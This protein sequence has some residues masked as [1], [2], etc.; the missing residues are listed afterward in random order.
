MGINPHFTI[1]PEAAK[2]L[3][4]LE[5]SGFEAYIV[6]GAV[7]D[8][9]MGKIPHDWDITTSALPEETERVFS[10]FRVVETG[11]KHGTVTVLINGIPL[12]IT[13]FRTESTYSDR[14]RPDS[15]SFSSSLYDDLSRRDFTC[16][17]LAYSPSKGLVDC[18]GGC[19]DIRSGVIKCVGNPETRFGEDALRIMRALRFSSELGF[20]IEENTSSA[21]HSQKNLLRY[22]SAERIFSE[23]LRLLCGNNVRKVL[24]GYYDVM[25]LLYPELSAMKGCLQNHERH[26][27]DVWGHTVESVGCIRPREEMRLAMLL[28]DCGKP[29]VRFTD[30]EGVDHFYSHAEKSAEAAEEILT[31]MKA[32]NR[33]KKRV[34]TLVKLHGFMAHEFSAK[35]MRRYIAEYG[36]DLISELF[37]IREADIRAQNPLFLSEGLEQNRKGKELFESVLSS[38]CVFKITDLDINGNDLIEA[39]VKPGPGIGRIL[40]ILFDETVSGNLA[41]EKSALLI[42]AGEIYNEN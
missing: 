33:M 39:G 28:H 16:N 5:E 22:V 36:S 10:G 1:S 20:D 41:N 14:R 3:E 35:T 27:Y 6:G 30:A 42:R 32:S 7:R 8:L 40:E 23:T 13:T 19:D 24:T 26:I 38:E 37:E 18:F 25:F 15:V 12:E 31:R 9:V 29:A 4:T 21:V 11:I 34:C 2:A 17:A